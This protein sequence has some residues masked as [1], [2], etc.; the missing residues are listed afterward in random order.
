MK[1][2][3]ILR[4]VDYCGAEILTEVKDRPCYRCGKPMKFIGKEKDEK[5]KEVG[6]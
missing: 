3:N 2:R 1:N 5:Q 6:K 4:C